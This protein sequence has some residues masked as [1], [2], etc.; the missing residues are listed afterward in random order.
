MATKKTNSKKTSIEDVVNQIEETSKLDITENVSVVEETPIVK[1]EKKKFENDE[2]IMC[3]SITEGELIMIGEKTKRVYKWANRGD[4]QPVE[5]QDLIYAIRINS[6][7][8]YKPRFIVLN[9]DVTR[10]HPDIL[11]VYNKMYSVNDLKQILKLPAQQ[12]KE[13]ILEMPIGAQESLK[14]LA[15]TMIANG[16]LDSVKSIKVLDDIFS[17]E[18]KFLTEFYA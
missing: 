3:Q 7:F 10:Q 5:Y 15:S 1:A 9:D 8:V 18:L 12:L 4:S 14:N 2:E 13:I 11:D 6:G 17:T 16:Q